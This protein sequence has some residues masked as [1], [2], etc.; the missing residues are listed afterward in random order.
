[1]QRLVEAL[2][3]S[4]RVELTVEA[5]R[6]MLEAEA[7]EAAS[8]VEHRTVLVSEAA[9]LADV[10]E[11]TVRRAVRSGEIEDSRPRR[12]GVIRVRLADVERLKGKARAKRDRH[13]KAYDPEAHARRLLTAI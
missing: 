7:Q 6:E 11:E 8:A 4:G 10:S 1:M 12:R 5:I 3:P 13:G 2:P 9:S